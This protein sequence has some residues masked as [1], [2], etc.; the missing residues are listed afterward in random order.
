MRQPRLYVALRLAAGEEL[1][2]PADAAN[3]LRVLRLSAGDPLTIFNGEGGEYPAVLLS[4]EK[5]SVRVRLGQPLFRDAESPLRVTLLQGISKGERMD[6][7]IQKAVELGVTT[8]LPLFAE[9]S[10]VQLDGERLRRR[11]QHWQGIVVSA[12]EQCGRNTLPQL[13]PAATLET[14]LE[15]IDVELPLVLDPGA[16]ATLRHCLA[17]RSPGGG[18]ALL[19]GPEGGFTAEEL[20]LSRRAGYAGVSLGPRVLRTE[21]AG[22]AALAAL[23]ALA[24][25]LG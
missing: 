4:L 10:V 9:R 15:R 6:Y 19:I 22:V 17:R 21:T 1:E 3:H 25:D 8:I 18:I 7:T 16:S 5:R 13:L 24:G 23:Q 12:C 11:E 2:L 20:A 14:A